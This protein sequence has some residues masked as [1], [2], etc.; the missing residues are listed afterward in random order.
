[1]GVAGLAIRDAIWLPGLSWG[2]DPPSS[3]GHD[4]TWHWS[5]HQ[6]HRPQLLWP[7]Q[8]CPT[9]PACAVLATRIG[10]SWC[11]ERATGIRPPK[12]EL[13]KPL[14]LG[15]SHARA[16]QARDWASGWPSS[17]TVTVPTQSPRGAHSQ[18]RH[19][20]GSGQTWGPGKMSPPQRKLD[21]SVST[22]IETLESFGMMCDFSRSPSAE[23]MEHTHRRSD[24]LESKDCVIR[25]MERKR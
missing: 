20:T 6:W 17:C 10:L 19:G 16:G 9:K 12:S 14:R 7:C 8:A 23:A 11:A 24:K 25:A 1:M 2:S 21:G 13:C 22:S 18:A 3:R 5:Q 15:G 4:Q